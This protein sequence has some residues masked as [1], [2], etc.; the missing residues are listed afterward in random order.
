MATRKPLIEDEPQ[1]NLPVPTT[2]RELAASFKPAGNLL[3]DMEDV[4]QAP[5][6]LKFGHPLTTEVQDGERA[7]GD[8]FISGKPSRQVI[9]LI[10]LEGKPYRSYFKDNALLCR[11]NDLITGE[12]EPGGECKVCPVRDVAKGCV[13]GH[14]FQAWVPEWE[15]LVIYQVKYRNGKSLKEIKSWIEAA[16]GEPIAFALSLQTRINKAG[17]RFLSA[18]HTL[19]EFDPEML[20]G[21]P[22]LMDMPEE[23]EELPF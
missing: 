13:D 5:S 9:T 14:A 15:A 7:Q 2:T 8:I 23:D 10:P 19:K 20:A 17:Q 3:A 11:S 4:G 6:F 16:Y 12:G 18:K 1:D 21:L 22:P